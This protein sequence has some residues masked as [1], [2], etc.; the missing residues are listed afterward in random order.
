MIKSMTAYGKAVQTFSLGRIE[1]EILTVNRKHLEVNTSLP[2]FLLSHDV[3]IKKWVSERI[4]RG[5]L[6][7]RVSLIA[8][9]AS[10]VAVYP[11]RGLAKQMKGA[12]DLIAADLGITI[13]DD[14]YIKI[15]LQEE[16]L[17]VYSEEGRSSEE[18]GQALKQVM[19]A[20]ID[21]C[22]SMK[23]A[24]GKALEDDILARLKNIGAYV[25]EIALRTSGVSERYRQ[26]LLQ[27]MN[28]VLQTS[29]LEDERILR[30]VALFAEKV[31]VSEEIT[32]LKSHLQQAQHVI[33][34]QG[35]QIGKTLEFIV[36]EM[37]R[38]A[39]TIGSKCVDVELSR[40]VID[41]KGEIERIREQIQ[42][43][44]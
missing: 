7:I 8:D 29:T 4:F 3:D 25:E 21:Q 35:Q 5:Q 10:P 17:L 20:A 27:R 23:E 2:H 34:G 9:E 16:G 38:E 41:V 30:E 24:E 1:V 15:L 36:Q 11:N 44:E 6:T 26:K 42:N 33:C 39:N 14:A 28:E 12:W 19:N 43:V 13:S 31:D 22:M 18:Y 37:N 40:F 32:R